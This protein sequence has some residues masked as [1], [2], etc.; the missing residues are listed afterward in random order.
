M[1]A[2]AFRFVLGLILMRKRIIVYENTRYEE[3]K[4]I[5]SVHGLSRI[6]AADFA[7]HGIRVNVVVPGFTLTPIVREIQNDPDFI[8]WLDTAI[9]LK[10]GLF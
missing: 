7:P 3:G 6:M 2:A 1:I 9:P 5:W 10:R 4:E 8:K